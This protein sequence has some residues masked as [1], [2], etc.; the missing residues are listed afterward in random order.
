[1]DHKPVVWIIAGSD[2]GAGAGIQADFLT[3]HD[4]GVHCCTVITAT[5][6]QNSMGINGIFPVSDESFL[7]QCNALAEDIQPDVIKIGLL[8]THR[9]VEILSAFI[10]HA[11]STWEKPCKIVYDPVAVA[12]TGEV[13]TEGELQP[14]IR[15]DLL[16]VVDVIT[17]NL[18]EVT[19]LTG[20]SLFDDLPLR[21]AADAIQDFG[22]EHVVITGGH[23]EQTD[24]CVDSYFSNEKEYTIEN[25][26]VK[27]PHSHGTGCSYASALAASMA[28]SYPIPDAM[29]LASAYIQQGLRASERIGQGVGAVKHLGWPKDWEHYPTVQLHTAKRDMS[30]HESDFSS[31]RLNPLGFYPVVD[32]VE[33]V[34]KLLDLGVET[35]QLRIKN[36]SGLA[37]RDKLD[38]AIQLAK[39][40]SAQLFI[41]DHWELAV[42]LGAY[43]VHLGQEDL[44]TADLLAIQKA[45]LRLGVSSHGYFEICTAMQCRPSYIAFG[46]IYPTTT[47]DMSGKIQGLEKLKRYVALIQDIPHVAIGGIDRKRAPEVLETG[48]K[49]L[50][51][52]RAVT[53]SKNLEA[54]VEAFQKM[55][56]KSNAHG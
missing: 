13:L 10:K 37:L 42:E 52:V 43:G 14:I 23:G 36:E 19:A 6:A 54:D 51:V 3:C 17:P 44:E 8:A 30:H 33:W 50:A 31:C 1:M 20:L 24:R 34:E 45:G 11:K 26:R 28:L 22:V 47:K 12:S 2:S 21:Q 15:Q 18:L 53:E 48:V 40:L 35:I 38:K 5:T 32:S 56:G 16:P 46:A 49:S 27:T 39:K 9:Q 4:F 29:V 7:A 25:Y 55:I 41:N